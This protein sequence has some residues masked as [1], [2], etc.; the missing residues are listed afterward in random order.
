MTFRCAY[1]KNEAVAAQA[2]KAPSWE[3]VRLGPGGGMALFDRSDRLE[4]WEADRELLMD[5][6]IVVG[7]API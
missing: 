1:K 5:M 2:S 3:G 6:D 7:A 4:F